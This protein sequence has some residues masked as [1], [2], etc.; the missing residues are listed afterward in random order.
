MKKYKKKVEY[1]KLNMSWSHQ[2]FS[3]FCITPIIIRS[4]WNNT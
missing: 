3:C 4:I 2:I 1:L